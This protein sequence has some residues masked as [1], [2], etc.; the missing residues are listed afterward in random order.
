LQPDERQN[1]ERVCDPAR[2]QLLCRACHS[3][4]TRREQR[5]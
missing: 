1:P 3:V 2:V 5:Q 4:K